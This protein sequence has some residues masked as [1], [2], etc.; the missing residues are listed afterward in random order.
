MKE[1]ICQYDGKN[2][3]CEFPDCKNKGRPQSKHADGSLYRRP[4]CKFHLKGKGREARVE[5]SKS[6]KKYSLHKKVK[7]HE[8]P[9]TILLQMP[10]M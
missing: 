9:Q 1:V 2:R 7:T 6:I 8:N 5:Y 10:Y 3:T 4:W